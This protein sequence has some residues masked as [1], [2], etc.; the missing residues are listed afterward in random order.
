MSPYRPGQGTRNS[1]LRTRCAN[2][3]ASDKLL[4]RSLVKRVKKLQAH[5]AN[6]KSWSKQKPGGFST[7][8][9]ISHHTRP[10]T[11]PTGNHRALSRT[12]P[13]THAGRAPRHIFKTAPL[14]SYSSCF[15]SQPG[16]CGLQHCARQAATWFLCL[17]SFAVTGFST[18]AGTSSQ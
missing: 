3:V 18:W 13:S 12:R 5:R 2:N 14:K 1:C 17:V 15:A 6:G 9:C 11:R 4:R 16:N 10:W 8:A 7:G